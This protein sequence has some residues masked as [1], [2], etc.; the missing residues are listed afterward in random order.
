MPKPYQL[1]YSFSAG[2][3][4]TRQVFWLVKHRIYFFY[5]ALYAGMLEIIAR[6]GVLIWAYNINFSE[7]IAPFFQ[8]P[9]KAAVQNEELFL[10]IIQMLLQLAARPLCSVLRAES[11]LVRQQV[12][13]GRI[14]QVS[15]FPAFLLMCLKRSSY[16]NRQYS[17][18]ITRPVLGKRQAHAVY[19]IVW[20]PCKR[21]I[22]RLFFSKKSCRG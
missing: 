10:R 4:P 19:E 3:P 6:G 21:V 11:G 1:Y 14:K 18:Q 9:Y 8:L 15:R 22:S 2:Q 5:C 17:P 20:L 7:K 16:R 13:S 12:T